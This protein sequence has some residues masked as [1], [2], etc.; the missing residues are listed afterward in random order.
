V[1]SLSSSHIGLDALIF[2]LKTY[3]FK[4]WVYTWLVMLSH[5]ILSVIQVFHPL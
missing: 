4:I 1:L 3:T 2:S 5:A